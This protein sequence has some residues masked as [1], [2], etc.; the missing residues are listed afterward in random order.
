MCSSHR[1][2]EAGDGGIRKLG[3]QLTAKNDEHTLLFLSA[4]ASKGTSSVNE[5]DC[6]DGFY[7]VMRNCT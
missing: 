7:R 5:K 3:D 2:L 1:T 6:L 4:A